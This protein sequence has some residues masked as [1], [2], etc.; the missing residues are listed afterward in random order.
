MTSF[1]EFRSRFASDRHAGEQGV[2][3]G[4]GRSYRKSWAVRAAAMGVLA[5]VAALAVTVVIDFTSQPVRQ[6]NRYGIV[7]NISRLFPDVKIIVLTNNAK[8]R[9]SAMRFGAD[10]VLPAPS[11]PETIGETIRLVLLNSPPARPV[12]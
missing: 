10:A 2:G 6:Q 12:P 8:L 3:G 5:G 9:E 11:A 1:E 7:R 4:S